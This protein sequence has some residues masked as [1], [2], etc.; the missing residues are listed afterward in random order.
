MADRETACSSYQCDMST[1]FKEEER[2][3]WTIRRIL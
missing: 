1:T 2:S 3:S